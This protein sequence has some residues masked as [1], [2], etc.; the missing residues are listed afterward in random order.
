MTSIHW[1]VLGCGQIA[2]TF[3]Q[4]VAKV[5][6]AKVVACAASN[7]VRAK[8][9][10]REYDIVEYYDSYQTM[11]NA[12]NIDAVYIATTHNFHY[13]QIILCLNHGKHVLC[14]KPLTL[15]AQQA[16]RVFALAEHKKL[17]LIEAVWTRFLPA[18][19]SMQAQLKDNI[20]G[21]IKSVYANFSL[22]VDVDESHRLKNPMLA[23]GAL[24]DLGI[25]PITLSD[26][27]FTCDPVKI[28][29][30]V[31][32]S[33]TKVD[34]NSFYTLEYTDGKTAQ[35]STGFTISRPT[36]AVIS[37]DKGF[38]K[39]PHFLGAQQYEMSIDGQASQIHQYPFAEG[40]NFVFEI[41]HMT[42]ILLSGELRSQVH[43]TQS[44]MR[45][46]RIMDEIRAQWGL[47]YPNEY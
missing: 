2:Q 6:H 24:L 29:S 7:E 47:V 1:A 25:Y 37:G 21:E 14:E 15:N 39:I 27:V 23:G 20:L 38:I 9:F 30:S 31:I 46:M 16:E 18:I 45:V 32:R 40:D 34:E 36:E 3:M 35:L 43:S 26:L 12:A 19:Q 10:A 8:L 28:T 44:T 13:E 11:L 41:E 5:R 17:L 33:S 4:S 22:N 42:Q